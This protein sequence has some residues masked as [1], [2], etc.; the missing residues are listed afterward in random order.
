MGATLETTDIGGGQDAGLEDNDRLIYRVND[1]TSGV[2]TV[3][4]RVASPYSGAGFSLMDGEGKTLATI[5]VPNTGGWQVWK[6]VTATVTLAAGQQQ[7]LVI[8]SQKGVSWNITWMEF[9]TQSGK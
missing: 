5:A 4:F 1:N 3:S 7:T 8:A 2:Y 6:T 9:E